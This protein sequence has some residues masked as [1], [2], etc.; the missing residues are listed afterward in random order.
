[1]TRHPAALVWAWRAVAVVLGASAAT[2]APEPPT[3]ENEYPLIVQAHGPR[4]YNTTNACLLMLDEPAGAA[5]AADTARTTAMVNEGWGLAATA[6]HGTAQGVAFGVEDV[7]L[8]PSGFDRC[9]YFDGSAR[10]TLDDAAGDFDFSTLTRFSFG[11]RFMTQQRATPGQWSIVSRVDDGAL[12]TTRGDDRGWRLSLVQGFDG[13]QRL[14]FEMIADGS[15]NA[16]IWCEPNVAIQPG[17]AYSVGCTYGGWGNSGAMIVYVR[18]GG[19][20][21]NAVVQMDEAGWEESPQNIRGGTLRL[22]GDNPQLDG[23]R[24]WL[25]GFY[26]EPRRLAV[27]DVNQLHAAALAALPTPVYDANLGVIREALRHNCFGRVVGDSTSS[28][29]GIPVGN[30]IARRLQLD[31]LI[32]HL[33][34]YFMYT[35]SVVRPVPQ[36]VGLPGFYEIDGVPTGLWSSYVP[37]KRGTYFFNFTHNASNVPVNATIGEFTDVFGDPAVDGPSRV[38]AR[39]VYPRADDP[40]VLSSVKL[41][42]SNGVDTAYG[43]FEPRG[44]TAT[45]ATADVAL[46][47]VGTTPAS[48]RLLGTDENEAGK[49]FGLYGVWFM[50]NGPGGG[51]PPG[52]WWAGTVAKSGSTTY[53][54]LNDSGLYTMDRLQEFDD[55]LTAGVSQNFEEKVVFVL[56]TIN[57]INSA[58]SATGIRTNLQAIANRW[59][60]R[61]Y[62]VCLVQPWA[63]YLT[64]SANP[65][66][67]PL[68]SAESYWNDAFLP[69]AGGDIGVVSLHQRFRG[70]PYQYLEGTESPS[71]A[72]HAYNSAGALRL[73][74]PMSRSLKA[75]PYCYADFNG[76]N[77]TTVQDIFD[78]LTAWLDGN[79]SAD[80]NQINGVTV[81]DI[82]DFLTLW[83]NGCG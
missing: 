56:L 12:G 14:R 9:A 21:T 79:P 48:L 31:G 71:W 82:F 27:E 50:H 68:N 55:V 2:A 20:T 7:G 35:N 64:N 53:A 32:P 5:Q 16:K 75:A 38:Q 3:Y 73:L 57:D 52:L 8:M 19:I 54:H 36:Y 69:V 61:G 25:A 74:I 23:F 26:V 58:F 18:G 10:I 83:L 17:V 41:S 24:G 40:A 76:L 43:T 81:Q 67:I 46:D 11:V 51:P 77:G 65:Q 34:A 63:Q 70:V 44:A 47:S 6:H 39:V 66:A 80:V 30:L 72:V 49:Q 62:K 29:E 45:Y 28:I 33:N 15:T 1:M 4:R 22:G 13:T 59:I 42:L 37:S 60:D 78:F